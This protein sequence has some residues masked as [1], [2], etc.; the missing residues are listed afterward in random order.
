MKYKTVFCSNNIQQTFERFISYFIVFQPNCFLSRHVLGNKGS[1]FYYFLLK[2]QLCTKKNQ[3]NTIP[4]KSIEIQSVKF[5]RPAFMQQLP[6]LRYYIFP[7]MKFD[8]FYFL[9]H[10][11]KVNKTVV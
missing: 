9:P 10:V 5:I 4:L 8:L 6:L 11:N 2:W 7:S 1:E 3:S